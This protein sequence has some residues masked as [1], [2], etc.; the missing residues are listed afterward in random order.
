MVTFDLGL[1]GEIRT[2]IIINCVFKHK[3]IDHF[4]L[5]LGKKVT[6]ELSFSFPNYSYLSA[7]ISI[8]M[9]AVNQFCHIPEVCTIVGIKYIKFERFFQEL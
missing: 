1:R 6:I 2:E 4:C 8:L 5:P 9:M 7:R 3:H